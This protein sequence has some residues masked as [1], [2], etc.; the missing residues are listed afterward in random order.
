[1]LFQFSGIG[2]SNVYTMADLLI[3]SKL[4]CIPILD[5]CLSFSTMN[6]VDLTR[7]TFCVPTVSTIGLFRSQSRVVEGKN[8]ITIGSDS[9]AIG[10][11]L[12]RGP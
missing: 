3:Q 12:F 1:M 10:K 8:V 7:V 9:Y 6:T 11:V 5:E 2:W 4:E